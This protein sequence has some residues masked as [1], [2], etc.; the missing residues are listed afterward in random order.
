MRQR[1]APFEH[2]ESGEVALVKRE[3]AE[4]SAGRETIGQRTTFERCPRETRGRERLAHE[5]G[6]R[7]AHAP[8]DRDPIERN[9]SLEVGE[10]ASAD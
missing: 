2:C 1:A 10:D 9:A 7:L 3:Q 5:V 4:K 8:E 6:I